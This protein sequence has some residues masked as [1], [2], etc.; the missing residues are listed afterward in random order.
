MEHTP[1]EYGGPHFI[2]DRRFEP[3]DQYH[4]RIP[5]SRIGREAEANLFPGKFAY[6]HNGIQGLHTGA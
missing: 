4:R 5:L 3:Q 2:P 1:F 6:S